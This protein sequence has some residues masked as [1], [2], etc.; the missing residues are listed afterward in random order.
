MEKAKNVV[1][2]IIDCLREDRINLEGDGEEVCPFLSSLAKKGKYFSN[3]S[4]N[5]PQISM[6]F[7]TVFTSTFP[8][9]EGAFGKL[10]KYSPLNKVPVEKIGSN[11]G[12]ISHG[13]LYFIAI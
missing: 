4:A 12:N 7:L 5:A 3:F 9:E 11:G 8:L 6:A 1:L 2:I 13:G 10:D